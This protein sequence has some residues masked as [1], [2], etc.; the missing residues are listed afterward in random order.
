MY[1]ET[2]YTHRRKLYIY[3]TILISYLMIACK[4]HSTIKIG[5][6]IVKWKIVGKSD[7]VLLVNNL[8]RACWYRY[9]YSSSKWVTKL[10][11]TNVMLY[12]YVCAHCTLQ[13]SLMHGSD[14]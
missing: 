4:G 11:S 6:P 5:T 2:I 14:Q 1:G 10:R 9:Q 3:S 13:E 8:T 7:P 12:V